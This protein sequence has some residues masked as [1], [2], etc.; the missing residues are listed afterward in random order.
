MRRHIGYNEFVFN[1]L[2]E[3][4]L[5]QFNFKKSKEWELIY[6]GS[7]KDISEYQYVMVYVK[8]NNIL[9]DFKIV[10]D[11]TVKSILKKNYGLEAL[12]QLRSYQN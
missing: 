7:C 10:K 5:D 3:N 8:M 4:I 11:P 9:D 2:S 6:K 1:E 12:L